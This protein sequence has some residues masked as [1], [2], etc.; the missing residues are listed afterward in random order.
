MTLQFMSKNDRA[1]GE[2]LLRDILEQVFFPGIND[3]QRHATL[4]YLEWIKA[5]GFFA[6]NGAL[7]TSPETGTAT[8]TLKVIVHENAVSNQVKHS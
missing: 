2:K 3:T 5:S 1:K 8:I 4:Q 6:I 7:E